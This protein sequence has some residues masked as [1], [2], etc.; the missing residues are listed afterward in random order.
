M[1]STKN[2]KVAELVEEV[3]F[4]KE[5]YSVLTCIYGGIYIPGQKYVVCIQGSS[6]S[7]KSTLA[8]SLFNLLT[9]NGLKCFLLET[10][11][12]YKT[13]PEN[14]TDTKSY[15]FD[16]PAALDW[17]KIENVLLALH[18]DQP[19]IPCYEYSFITKKSKGPFYIPNNCPDI[20]II[21]GIYSFNTINHKVFDIKKFNPMKSHEMNTPLFKDPSFLFSKFKVLKVR[22]SVCK[23]KS[24]KVRMARD[25]L[26]RGK[27]VEQVIHQFENQVWPATFKWVNS[28]EFRENIKLIHG[29]FNKQ[30]TRILIAT[31][32]RYFT[33]KFPVQNDFYLD[34]DFYLKAAVMCSKECCFESDADLILKDDQQ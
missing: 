32:C 31:I 14:I 3:I 5:I 7:G 6:S 29:T 8:R 16:N 18:E 28:S 4:S 1:K 34:G 33:G 19:V 21:E 20:I 17:E 22:L 30:Q 9:S 13:F 26:L 10:D 12:Y 24:F 2:K 27:S 25:L 15:D 11:K 23:S